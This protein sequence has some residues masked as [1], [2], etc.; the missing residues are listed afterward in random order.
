MM[1][2][3][4]NSIALSSNEDI[5]LSADGQISHSAGGS[6]NLS[7]QKS[8]VGHASS[9][10]SLFAAQ[11][12]ARLYAGKGK[13]EVQAQDGGADLI[14]RKGIQIISTEDTIYIISPKEIKL[15]GDGSEVKLNGSG[16]F[17]T[18]GGLFE[19]KSG[20]QKFTGGAKVSSEIPQLPICE[21]RVSGAAAKVMLLWSFHNVIST[22][23][24]KRND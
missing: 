24:S 2:A 6:I 13:V 23:P 8:L 4:P 20:Q 19:V 10:I 11:E 5:H 22:Y 18:T 1:L 15:I 17:A 7:T 21:M 3:S 14:A 16:V 12:G 9:K